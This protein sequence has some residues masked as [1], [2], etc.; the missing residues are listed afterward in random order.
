[1]AVQFR[2]LRGS[3]G[4][5]PALHPTLAA[6]FIVM[7]SAADLSE[8]GRDHPRI[9]EHLYY[10]PGSQF[11]GDISGLLPPSGDRWWEPLGE[12]IN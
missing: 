5:P 8:I 4:V 7:D 1:V 2:K 11:P 3:N 10:T 6:L 12:S 9:E